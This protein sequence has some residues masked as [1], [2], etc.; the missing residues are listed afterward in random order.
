MPRQQWVMIQAVIPD[1]Y[2]DQGLPGPQPPFPGGGGRPPG[3]P[4]NTLP[5]PQPIPGW[6]T[7]P[8]W[9]G[10]LPGGPGRPDGIWGPNDPRPTPPIYIPIVLPPDPEHPDI[11]THPIYIP[12]YPDNALPGQ[13]PYPDNTLPRPTPGT[14]AKIKKAIEFW[15]GNLP[16]NP[17]PAPTPT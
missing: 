4:D 14:I 17:N 13:Q 2:P 6:P 10:S 16:T 15:T 5:G 3:Y 7:V 1:N 8:G 12:V 11:P 9:G